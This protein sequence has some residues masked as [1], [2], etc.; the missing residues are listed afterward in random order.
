MRK[1][2]ANSYPSGFVLF[3]VQDGGTGFS[4]YQQKRPARFEFPAPGIYAI[5]EAASHYFECSLYVPLRFA[6]SIRLG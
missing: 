2:L 6:A 4:P 1:P 5:S 3:P